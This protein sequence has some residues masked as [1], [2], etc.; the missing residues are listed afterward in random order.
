VDPDNR[1]PVDYEV[2]Q[3]MLAELESGMNVE[4]IMKRMDSGMPKLWVTHQALCLRREK[5][6]WFGASAAY[7]PLNIE[8]T[9]K[10]HLV[11]YLR[12]DNVAT[13]VPRCTVRLGSSWAGTTVDLPPGRWKNVLTGDLLNG[14]RLRVQTVLQRFPVALLTREGD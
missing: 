10:E 13:L 1:G 3:A 9:K 6:E 4:E 2:R 7:T 8:G 5:P 12:G 14:P 11:A